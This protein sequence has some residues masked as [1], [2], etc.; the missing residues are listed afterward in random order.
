MAGRSRSL[1]EG[2]EDHRRLSVVPVALSL[3]SGLLR[4]EHPLLSVLAAVN[5]FAVPH[6]PYPT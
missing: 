6:R 4:C 2:F 5:C 1:R 3:L